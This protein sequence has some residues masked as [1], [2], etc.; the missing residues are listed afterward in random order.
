VL[1]AESYFMPSTRDIVRRIKS[2]KNTKKITKAMEMVSSSKMRKA[3]GGVLATRPYATLAWQLVL[4][5]AG[6]TKSGLHPLLT[7]RA[8]VKKIAL[9][10]VSSNRGL[11]GSFNQQ[12][13]RVAKEYL[14][15]AQEKN[16][17]L[18]ADFLVLGRKSAKIISRM[19]YNLV[20]EFEKA[21]VVENSL[22]IR[23]LAKMLVK[24]F[25]SG[26]YDQVVLVYTDYISSLRQI[27]RTKQILPIIPDP[28]QMLGIVEK[29][30]DSV[31]GSVEQQ[32]FEYLF[33]P[34][35]KIILQE[36]L[37]RLL[38]VQVYQALL[39][40]NASE[41]SARM[42]AMRNASDAAGDMINELT[43]IYN[44]ARQAAI[45]REIAEIAGGKA[46]LE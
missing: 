20:A 23:P 36:L 22:S 31:D 11:C 32:N 15:R 4:S 27:A 2:V 43:L 42:L 10:L 39:E 28:D 3:V 12:V 44:Q 9:V 16:P 18:A 6:K 26:K 38:E 19:G 37:P 29:A 17:E 13:V 40:S 25:L 41:H 24:D 1:K 8:Q 21:D 7:R 35:P 34:N 14:R 45:T 33:E 46:A 30:V 5:V